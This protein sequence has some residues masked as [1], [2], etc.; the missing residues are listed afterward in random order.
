MVPA[1]KRDAVQKAF[2]HVFGSREIDDIQPLTGG[3][4][5]ALVYKVTMDRSHYVMRL[6]TQ[7]DEL[8]DPVR[9]FACMNAAGAAGIAPAVRYTSA[10][11]AISIVDFIE[12]T[13][14][15]AE[16]TSDEELF[17]QLATKVKAIHALPLFPGLVGFL[18]GVDSLIGR[19]EALG[20]LPVRMT[21]EYFQHYAVIRRTYPGNG[22]E[23]VS[24]HNDLNPS[25]VLHHGGKVWIIDWEAAFANDRYVD[26]AI[27]NLF[28]G[29]GARGEEPL[30]ET[31]FGAALDDYHRARFFLMR[32][33]CFMYYCMIF[34]WL[35]ST[36]RTP[37]SVF[38]TG[39]ETMRLQEFHRRLGAG[40]VSMT[41]AEEYLLYA[42][43]LMNESM[44]Q[45]KSP[46]FK[47]SVR[48]LGAG[49][50][51]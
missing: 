17:S 51:A 39:L 32:Q 46:R 7:I 13:P 12:H 16:F 33:V 36:T 11:D 6:V 15:S 25:N 21:E 49:K 47:E 35:A 29:S 18:D 44:S 48:L 19:Y 5:S 42:K 41:S 30:L 1:G 45:M 23:L 14:L 37:E 22:E 26:L 38:S 28:F 24:S 27:V 31:Y 3:R 8:R 9:H 43:I 50:A 4:S 20:V 34:M 40:E 2:E 10:E